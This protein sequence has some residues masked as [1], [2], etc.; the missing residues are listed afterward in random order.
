M[1]GVWTRGSFHAY[2]KLRQSVQWFLY[3]IVYLPPLHTPSTA[4]RHLPR[5]KAGCRKP[6][7]GVCPLSL[8]CTLGLTEAVRTEQASEVRVVASVGPNPMQQGVKEE[9]Q[10]AAVAPG[11]DGA[12]SST[13]NARKV[14]VYK[15]PRSRRPTRELAHTLPV[16]RY[17][18]FGVSAVWYTDQLFKRAPPP[19]RPP[20][21]H[22]TP[23]AILVVASLL[24]WPTDLL[25]P[26]RKLTK[27]ITW[28]S[29]P[30]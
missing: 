14:C 10:P 18:N 5:S 8:L 28:P 2:T 21:P 15:F 1:L 25:S 13:S 30:L 16:R 24:V 11:S 17:D 29:C 26:P 20:S 3:P 9:S 19:H 4:F 12:A 6:V 23:F 22:P 7:L 27:L